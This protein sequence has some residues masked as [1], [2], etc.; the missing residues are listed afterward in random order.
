MTKSEITPDT[1][2]GTP[3]PITVVQQ[4]LG[5]WSGSKADA[6]ASFDKFFTPETV[7]DNVGLT[8][9]VGIDEAR[10]LAKDV[11]PGYETMIADIKLIVAK[12][13]YVFTERVDHF[14][15]AT[16]DLLVSIRGAGVAEVQ[17][18][19]ILAMREYFIPENPETSDATATNE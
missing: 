16:G 4:F 11:V 13:R 17:N 10:A 6:I 19:R 12:G 15:T 7:W 3:D 18:G 8:T 2:T 5:R 9:T 14:Y 1:T